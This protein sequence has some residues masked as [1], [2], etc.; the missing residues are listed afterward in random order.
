[1]SSV[2]IERKFIIELPDFEK[3]RE[4]SGYTFYDIT[5]V[6]MPTENGVSHRIRKRIGMRD[7]VYTET[8]KRRID[9]MSAY[10]DEAVIT[11]ERYD[12]LYSMRD[13]SLNVISKRRHTFTFS[14]Q[15]FEIDV[16]P[17]WQHSCIMETELESK[18]D[19]PEIPDFIRIVRD[20]TGIRS[21]SNHSMA[22]A[23]PD[24]L[25]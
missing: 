5:Q 19:F 24:E 3:M 15:L 23:F 20:V 1:M 11:K 21:Y 4:M 9:G 22:S 12:E 7:V 14:G 10:E 16:Y 2:E 6:Y 8:K 17:N 25:V 18:K 13:K